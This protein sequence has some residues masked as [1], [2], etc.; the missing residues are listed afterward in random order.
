MNLKHGMGDTRFYQT[1][2]GMVRRCTHPIPKD[3]KVYGHVNLHKPWL[4]FGKFKE[5]MYAGYLVC[6]KRYEERNVTI[7][8]R[9][10]S[11]GYNPSNCIWIPKAWQG[12]NRKNLPSNKSGY[13]GVSVCKNRWRARIYLDR[14]PYHLGVF[15]TPKEAYR[16]YLK[17][18]KKLWKT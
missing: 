7:E 6:A 5:D 1:W 15:D 11:K 13:V 16:A 2:Y 3:I 18:K 17:A 12:R 9:D 14:K 10:N 8:R 4:S